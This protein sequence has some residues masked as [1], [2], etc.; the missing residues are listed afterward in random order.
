MTELSEK[1]LNLE[2]S[3]QIFQDIKYFISGEVHEKV[4]N[5]SIVK[6]LKLIHNI[7]LVR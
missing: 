1:F 6:T 4:G 5:I 3:E 7:F 2:I